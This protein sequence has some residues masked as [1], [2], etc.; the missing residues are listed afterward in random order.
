[1]R[2]IVKA[3]LAGIIAV[4]APQTIIAA[5]SRLKRHICEPSRKRRFLAP[6]L[7]C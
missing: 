4:P 5:A 3:L 7:V 1:M 6:G 2:L